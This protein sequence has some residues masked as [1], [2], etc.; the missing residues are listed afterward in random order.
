MPK[1]EACHL[2]I[3]MQ[4]VKGSNSLVPDKATA[5][6]LKNVVHISNMRT[7]IL[8]F[9]FNQL[10]RIPPRPFTCISF[11]CRFIFHIDIGNI[12]HKWI[13]WIRVSK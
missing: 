9:Y 12:G 13:T 4:V 11:V 3:I 8:D 5:S 1:R 7:T 10:Y 2:F 6:T